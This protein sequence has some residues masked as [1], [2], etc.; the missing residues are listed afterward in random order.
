MSLG[1]RLK[2]EATLIGEWCTAIKLTSESERQHSVTK[3]CSG[4]F[5]YD[6]Q[7]ATHVRLTSCVTPEL[8]LRA[9][10]LFLN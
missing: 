6:T 9:L 3:D 2:L 8:F 1:S 4:R 7:D 10:G 5:F